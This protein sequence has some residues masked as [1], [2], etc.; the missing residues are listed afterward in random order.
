MKKIKKILISVLNQRKSINYLHLVE[1]KVVL[2]K[3]K[4]ES[5]FIEIIRKEAQELVYLMM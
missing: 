5:H 4:R 1:S 3:L 2:G